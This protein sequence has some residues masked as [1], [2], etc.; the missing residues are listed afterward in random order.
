MK[1]TTPTK[2]RPVWRSFAELAGIGRNAATSEA[3]A[4]KAPPVAR[5]WTAALLPMAHLIGLG[6]P[7]TK[8]AGPTAP[9]AARRPAAPVAAPVRAVAASALPVPKATAPL[10]VARP[11]LAHEA[12]R[13]AGVAAGVAAERARWRAIFEGT[14]AAAA[15]LH[16]F[17]GLAGDPTVSVAG[18]V[19]A[20]GK[21]PPPQDWRRPDRAARN[22]A[23]GPGGY[24]PRS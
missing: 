17:A 16:A 9:A 18:A 10:L 22:P 4:P 1:T 23:L 5:G 12:A 14:P 24:W 7:T 21:L 20:L 6:R 8:P 15:N 11:D 2:T 3:P 13:A 19:A